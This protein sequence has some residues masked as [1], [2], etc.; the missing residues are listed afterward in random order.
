MPDDPALLPQA[1]VP[2]PPAESDSEIRAMNAVVAA[3]KPLTEEER[4]RVLGYILG[5]FGAVPIQPAVPSF[6]S[7]GPSASAGSSASGAHHAG[8]GGIH[9]IRTLKEAKAPKSANE[10]AAL[11]AFYVLSW[12]AHNKII[13]ARRTS[14]AG[15]DRELAKPSSSSRSSASKTNVAFG[16]PIAIGTSIVHRRCLHSQQYYCQ[17]FMGQDTSYRRRLVAALDGG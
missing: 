9:D 4:R 16:R 11:V 5:R 17:L 1:Q 10:M 6:A 13:L 8:A 7:P 14:P 2:Q 3:L 12:L 15:R